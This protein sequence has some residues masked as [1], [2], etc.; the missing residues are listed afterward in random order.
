[1]KKFSK[2][3]VMLLVLTL[4][5]SCFAV[6]AS[7][8]DGDTAAYDHK[9]VLEYFEAGYYLNAD[10]NASGLNGV[11]AFADC[12]AGEFS[13]AFI[14]NDIK[15]GTNA[16][17][18]VVKSL[19]AKTLTITPEKYGS[20]GLN[21]Y[22][23][24][25]KGIM[26]SS[27]K[28]QAY[29]SSSEYVNIFD[30]ANGKVTV[31]SWDSDSG[32]ATSTVY[33]DTAVLNDTF[34][35]TE[36]FFDAATSEFTVEVTPEGGETETYTGSLKGLN[37]A[38]I[39]IFFSNI[40]FDYLEV[41]KGTM[42]RRLVGNDNIIATHISKIADLYNAAPEGELAMDY[43]EVVS[44]VYID[45][46]YT[47]ANVTDAALKEK[48][49]AFAATALKRFGDIYAASFVTDAPALASV[50][51]YN[52]KL[53][54]VNKLN[55][56]DK[57]LT[58]IENDFADKIII[59]TSF[60]DI[61]AAR[62]LLTEAEEWLAKSKA[63]T[64]A[65]M[66]AAALVPNIYYATYA[67]LKEFYDVYVNA[68]ICQSF[69]NESI[70]AEA[71]AEAYKLAESFKEEFLA[72]DAKAKLFTENTTVA[73]NAENTFLVRYE[74][75]LLASSNIFSDTT[76]N[77]YVTD[78]T[79]EQLLSDYA[80]VDAYMIPIIDLAENFIDKVAEA[81]GTSSYS[82][83]EVALDKAAEYLLTVEKT[84][85]GVVEAEA[86]YNTV[87]ADVEAKKAATKEYILAVI[88]VR[89]AADLDA[90]FAAVE[91]AKAKAEAGSDVSVSI[92]FSEVGGVTVADA[93]V[94]LS[95]VEN[96]IKLENV[97][98]TKYVDAVAA[99]EKA[100]TLAEQRAAILAAR[101]A[102]SNAD[103]TLDSV[104]AANAKLDAAIAA[105]NSAV[106]SANNESAECNE[107]A[108]STVNRT[109]LTKTTAEIVAIIKKFFED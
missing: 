26:L 96:E 98:S 14:S 17:T 92:D 13:S 43:L 37:F 32:A 22:S 42:P 54:A 7:A 29:I 93:N 12:S 27:F 84:Y 44:K 102:K 107:V 73:A 9:Q 55:V 30:I 79:V 94:I 52:A 61:A 3:L 31:S 62:V 72:R 89:D 82:V 11:N 65:A 67:D 34:F 87:L 20:F 39:R 103:E 83:K 86:L 4:A 15:P 104:I 109:V 50:T 68:P 76:Y 6:F 8:D 64:E 85:P 41:Y 77:A 99:I 63:D 105:Y 1:M 16:G 56:Y 35:T 91:I 108:V 5:I 46:G 59:A 28:L 33:T 88:A 23:S 66:A 74:A 48:V 69:Y 51:D 24:L 45:Y 71:V 57:L 60:E 106:A 47:T 78:V 36:M 58:K 97:R 100:D 25:Q 81:N 10:F 80:D 18:G 2:L 38:E 53:E 49:D 70:T 90:K 101:A 40:T 19:M 21:A 95:T 75:Y